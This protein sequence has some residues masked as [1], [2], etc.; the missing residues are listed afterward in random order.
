[1][2]CK[3]TLVETG[4]E[5]MTGG[6]LNRLRN[7]I[8]DE[9]FFLTYGDGVSNINIKELLKNHLDS[10]KLLTMSIVRPPARFGVLEINEKNVLTE[11]EEKP[12][13]STGWI[14]GGFF[15]VEPEFLD[16]CKSDNEMLEREPIKR[17]LKINQISAYKHFGFWKCMDTLR[18][19]NEL[20]KIHKKGNP[21]W[22]ED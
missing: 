9:R 14:N 5:T 10:K 11:F 22:L 1:M 16:F 13:L 2:D 8:S 20:E 4:L 15:V 6:R 17:A 18:D 21:P 3:V 19:K 7:Y 12:Q